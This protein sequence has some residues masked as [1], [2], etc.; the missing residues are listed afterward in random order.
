MTGSKQAL[1][2]KRKKKKKRRPKTT[3]IE[4]IINDLTYELNRADCVKSPGMEK[5]DSYNKPI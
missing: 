4:M 2:K 1:K 3:W 5:Y